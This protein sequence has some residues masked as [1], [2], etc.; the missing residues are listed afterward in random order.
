MG[1]VAD[2]TRGPVRAA[3]ADALN[4]AL[5]GRG[6]LVLVTGEAGIGKTTTASAVADSARRA[7]A[8]VRWAACWPGGA[9]VAHGPWL[10]VLAGLGP[11]GR[12]AIDALA[13]TA[14]DD[15]VAAAS[16]R[17]SAYTAVADAIEDGA[18]ARPLVIVLDDLHWADA[19]T[20][21]LLAAVAGRLPSFGALVV[22][23]YRD[24]DIGGDAPLR[25]LGA[26]VDRLALRGLD[27]DE[28]A[29]MLT[30]ALGPARAGELAPDVVERTGGNPFL[31]VQL[32]RLVAADPDAL[33]RGAL[34]AGAR[35]LLAGRLAALD[36]DERA[37]I[38]AAAVLGGAFAT[39]V[40]RRVVADGDVAVDA[41]LDRA[42]ALRIVE[43]APGVD[44]WRFVH[45]LLRTAAIDGLP[46]TDLAALHA[47]AA[48]ALAGDDDA[49]PAVV[50]RHVLG[51][52][53][54]AAPWFVR[55]G[56][57]ALAAMAWEEAATQFERAL[58]VSR[59]R[60]RVPALLGLGRARILSGDPDDAG[61]AFDEVASLARDNGETRWLVDAALGFS[62]DL[63]GFEV[64]LFD[65]RQIDLLEEA[66]AALAS[67]DDPASVALRST[68]MARLSVA[69]SLAA[70]TARRL[71]LAEDAV[72]LARASGDRVALAR[73]LAAHCDAIAGPDDVAQRESE[74]S[75][76]IA[77][78]DEEGD[79]PLELLGRRLRY[80]ARL[81]SG[82]AAGANA[83]AGAFE[84]RAAAVGNPLY[85]WYADL[86]RG[87][88]A[89][90]AGD[91]ATADAMCRRVAEVGRTTGSANAS[92]LAIVLEL[93]I[94]WARGDHEGAVERMG[95]LTA[96]FPEV[97]VFL[98]SVGAN[99]RALA[100]AG[101]D[102]AARELL[103]RTQAIGLDAT[104]RD[105]E[106]LPNIVTLLDTAVMLRHP[107]LADVLGV[108][109]PYAALVAFEGIGA[110][111]YGSV[112]RFVARAC[113][114]LGRH[115]DAIAYARTAL[116]VNRRFGARLAADAS[117]TL[118]DVLDAAGCTDSPAAL[119]VAAP[120]P[121]ALVRDGDVWHITFAGETTIV[122]HTKGVADLA[123]L[124]AAG[125]R[126]VHVSELVGVDASVL[127][128]GG[129]SGDA[130][131]RRAVAAYRDRLV[132]LAE[133]IDDADAAHDITRAERARI[134]HDAVVEQLAA[135]LGLGG[136]ARAA[137]PDPVERSRKAVAARLRDAIRRIDA[138]HPTL[139]RHLD[140]SI[141]TG[142]FCSYRPEHPVVWRCE[143]SSGAGR[144]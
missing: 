126:E 143:P 2:R 132:E 98:S 72:A 113:S 128:A 27:T 119:P 112:A 85:T 114:A 36:D 51:A 43:R 101:Y 40:L 139:G 55:A 26:S 49:E 110:G 111:L 6:G 89:V 54:D 95:A 29:A 88:M 91:D 14:P 121:A 64:R 134:E 105:A 77:I 19:G 129:R 21:Q 33:R 115:D 120:A 125:G 84:R 92:M 100:L 53:G 94:R 103:D 23:T 18:T 56:D 93:M 116:D 5:D 47:R 61:R 118:A 102:D 109:E 38:V 82:D 80:V 71:T 108:V 99:A 74:A 35:D 17:A 44:A 65:Q 107:L 67:A 81:E 78:A 60:A 45:D 37:V 52:G 39:D 133:E 15:G 136:R 141:K 20:V 142:T 13:S 131:D 137:G 48:D 87:E 104:V 62:A 7:G 127:R 12:A 9:T 75:E 124:L 97:A 73:A 31:V 76:I 117:Q 11:P 96:D 25:R 59:G 30:D 28:V 70:P 122:K 1:A 144:A 16:L 8:T 135:G 34:P 32:G 63:S 57:R 83:D 79:G 22:G 106:W 130:L 69:L 123:V 10:T 24:T 138:I 58:G 68:V 140:V 46:S 66:V 90:V 50:A 41:A 4:G 86:W 3:L 42:A